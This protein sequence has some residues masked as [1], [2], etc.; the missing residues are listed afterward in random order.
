MW[1]LF[2]LRS[3]TLLANLIP[4]TASWMVGV[5]ILGRVSPRL[6]S[7]V[8]F[9]AGLGIVLSAASAFV[10]SSRI[11]AGIERSAHAVSSTADEISATVDQ[12]E[13]LSVQQAAA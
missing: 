9:G 5:V 2:K 1:R 4:L 8:L 7:A 13:R 6:G 11:V 10:L 3:L 12:R